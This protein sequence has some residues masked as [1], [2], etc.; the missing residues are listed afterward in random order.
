[1]ALHLEDGRIAVADID[2]PGIF[3]GPQITHGASV[4]NFF[5]WTRELL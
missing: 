4:G 1:M 3:S 2:D 5:R